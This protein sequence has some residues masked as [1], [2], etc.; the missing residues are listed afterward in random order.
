MKAEWK[1]IL[2]IAIGI[3]MSVNT[4]NAIDLGGFA[5][6]DSGGK[7]MAAENY[8]PNYRRQ[9]HLYSTETTGSISPHR[10]S[11]RTRPAGCPLRPVPGS[12][13][14]LGGNSGASQDMACPHYK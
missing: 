5:T 14:P 1:P 8:S 13:Q 6:I 12:L 4:A 9:S 7:S 3:G 2:A 11:S 10:G